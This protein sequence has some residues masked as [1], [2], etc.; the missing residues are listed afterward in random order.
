MSPADAD[1]VREAVAAFSDAA[2]LEAAIDDLLSHGF[3]HAELSLL[4]SDEA[5]VEKLGHAFRSTRELEDDPD[6]PTVTYVAR[7][8][9]GDAE[10]ATIGGLMYVGA[11]VGLIP[12]IASG[13]AI[14]AAI[15]AGALLGGAGAGVGAL[16]ARAIG[17]AYAARIETQLEEGG[18]LLWVRTRDAAHERKAVD[19]LEAHGG[20][21]VHVHGLPEQYAALS[22]ETVVA[23]APELPWRR[24][25]HRG[26][27]M[28]EAP[29]GHCFALGRVF[30][31]SFEARRVIDLLDREG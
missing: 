10:G 22:P 13:G 7:E 25:V 14:G 28:L 26:Y 23:E 16:L 19:I 17:Q 11:M 12:V 9:V 6:V 24:T 5:I 20:K 15:A 21:D 8:T 4:A 2:G 30:V 3:D 18:L 1:L 29:D 27:E 31:N